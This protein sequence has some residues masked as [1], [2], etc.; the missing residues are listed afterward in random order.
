MADQL[1]LLLGD[2]PAKTSRLPDTKKDYK[3]TGLDFGTRCF[4]FVARWCRATSS[5]KTSQTSLLESGDAGLLPSS[6]TWPRS[7]MMCNGIVFRLPQLAPSIR[8]IGYGLLPTPTKSDG[9]SMRCFSIQS[10]VK[11]QLAGHQDRSWPSLLV[12]SRF[13]LK[14]YCRIIESLMGYPQLWT[15]LA[16]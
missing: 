7:G 12:I 8:E 14:R 3:A 6:V 9:M 5:W 16:P 2:S 15:R 11:S 1:M 13:D 10:Q 4:E